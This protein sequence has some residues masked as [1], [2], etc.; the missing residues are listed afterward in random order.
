MSDGIQGSELRAPSH[1][2]ILVDVTLNAIV[3]LI[4]YRLSKIYISPSEI[5]ALGISCVFPLAKS[6]FD[7]RHRRQLDP[8]AVVVLLGIATSAIA[9]LFGG[10]PRILLIRESMF[11]G[12]FGL[13][14]FAS[15]LLPRPMMFYFGRH[16]TAGDDPR[17][18]ERFNASWALPEV[19]FAHRLITVVW[20]AVY[21]LELVVRVILIYTVSTQLVLVLS[22]ILIGGGTVL[23]LAWTFRYVRI[24]RARIAQKAAIQTG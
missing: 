18:I 10:S 22:P 8:I 12:V 14:C 7:L 1:R 2:G 21:V 4:L 3:P 11:T 17:K 15:L 19:R 5:T 6:V 20:G 9:L 24:L 16:F 23:T 13:A